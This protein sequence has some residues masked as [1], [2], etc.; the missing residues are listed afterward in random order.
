MISTAC[1]PAGVPVLGAMVVIVG[2]AIAYFAFRI[3]AAASARAFG[4][5]LTPGDRAER[6]TRC[7]AWVR[8]SP[9]AIES[10]KKPLDQPRLH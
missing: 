2:T 6:G 10:K 8:C 5:A 3:A 1:P 7:V 4:G 9:P